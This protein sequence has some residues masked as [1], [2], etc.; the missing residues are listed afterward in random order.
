MPR[1]GLLGA[2]A[3]CGVLLLSPAAAAPPGQVY[4][5][6]SRPTAERVDDLLGQMTLAEKVGQM[7]QILV[8]HVTT[9]ASN[10]ACPGCF[11]DPDP[12]S[13]QAVLID[14]QV[15]SLL[16]G[17]TD[18]PFDASHS[19]GVGNTGRDWAVTYNGIQAFAVQPSR[20]HIPV[21][22]G[23]DAVHGF[24]HPVDAPLFPHAMGMGATWDTALAERAGTITGEALRSTGWLENF[25]PVQ[26]VYR[27][28][29][30]GRAYETWSEEPALA[31]SLGAASVRGV[32]GTGR[33]HRTAKEANPSPCW[34]GR[35]VQRAA[36]SHRWHTSPH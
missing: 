24:S 29:R 12:A 17:G 23:V 26:D 19:G 30:W 27:D 9:P 15:G 28:N 33:G 21:L 13:M 25:A 18:M 1:V 6:Q 31:G 7:D 3:L 2:V 22:F 34:P 11:G 32:C 8:G 35:R 4:R 10:R 16:A 5:D 36:D 14:N 20:L